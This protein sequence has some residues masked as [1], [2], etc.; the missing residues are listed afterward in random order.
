M[1]TTVFL[2]TADTAILNRLCQGGQKRSQVIR[3]LLQAAEARGIP[4]PTGSTLLP[5]DYSSALPGVA[6]DSHDPYRL[7]KWVTDKVTAAF[8]M[9]TTMNK[10]ITFP[11]VWQNFLGRQDTSLAVL[12]QDPDP[13]P[14]GG[15]ASTLLQGLLGRDLPGEFTRKRAETVKALLQLSEIAARA[16]QLQVRRSVSIPIGFS[17][18]VLWDKQGNAQAQI[19]PYVFY[20]GA[21]PPRTVTALG[22]DPGSRAL[23]SEIGEQWQRAVPEPGFP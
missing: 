8:L 16:D 3:Q 10:A 19:Q 6:I 23:L 11:N 20:P 14:A 22:D 12:L 21:R 15:S 4:S 18:I 9:G 7:D 17:A 13:V 2:S 1:A 5:D